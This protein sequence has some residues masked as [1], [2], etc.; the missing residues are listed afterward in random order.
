MRVSTDPTPPSVK[1]LVAY[2]AVFD[3]I[4]LESDVEMKKNMKLE[5]SFIDRTHKT[6]I[7][8][9]EVGADAPS[10]SSYYQHRCTYFPKN[11]SLL[12]RRLEVADSG[13]YQLQVEGYYAVLSQMF[14]KFVYLN[15]EEALSTPLIVQDPPYIANNVQLSC[16]V[17]NGRPSQLLWWREN[18]Q[19]T[20]S[21]LYILSSDNSTLSI[22]NVAKAHCGFY[23]CT[24]MNDISRRNIS[25]FLIVH[26]VQ[27][28]HKRILVASAVAMTSTI[29]SFAAVFFIIFFSLEKYK[30][31][32]YQTRLTVA[33]LFIEMKCYIALLISCILCALDTD[34]GIPYRVISGFVFCLLLGMTGYIVFLY[35][36]PSREIANSFLQD[37]RNRYIVLGF[38]VFTIMISPLPIY[39]ATENVKRC[40]L[41]YGDI[42]AAVTTAV[43]IYISTVGLCLI[44][45]LKYMQTW[46]LEKRASRLWTR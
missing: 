3:S 20:N 17:R 41:P 33:F 39:E 14:Y 36:R 44:F 40:T 7:A 2:G 12:L 5:W 10:L 42:A 15:I 43:M 22:S 24:V 16:I 18:L 46:N 19:I 25:H 45:A 26:G 13:V 29:I 9:H 28:L 32:K 34:V 8:F 21:S 11:G 35:L 30:G 38:G 4:I 1:R 27:F 31:Q 6:L 23:T 37:K